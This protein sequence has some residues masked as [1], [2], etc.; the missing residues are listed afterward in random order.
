[1]MS[2]SP[3]PVAARIEKCALTSQLAQPARRWIVDGP[4][5]NHCVIS[6]TDL[7]VSS[8]ESEFDKG[9]FIIGKRA[10]SKP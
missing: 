5:P 2:R 9:I 3:G 10:E 4:F 6:G 7:R 8:G 1:M